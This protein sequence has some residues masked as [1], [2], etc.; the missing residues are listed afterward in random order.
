MLTLLLDF[1]L[2]VLLFRKRTPATVIVG[3]TIMVL[4]VLVVAVVKQ[5]QY[6]N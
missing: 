2:A 3:I 1:I 5:A 4:I 6:V